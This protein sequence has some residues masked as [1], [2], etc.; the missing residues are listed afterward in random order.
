MA[1]HNPTLEYLTTT[2]IGEKGQLTVPKQ[3]REDLGLGIGAP[4]A[5]LRLGDGLILLPEQ[6]RFEQ[7]CERV[8]TS[9]TAAGLT[10][11][12]ILA[13]L[14]GARNRVFGRRYGKK[15]ADTGTG[16]VA[17]RRRRSQLGK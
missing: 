5:V 14:P 12:D 17:R 10:A 15:P 2:K 3:F 9:L 11:Q 8:R 7:L 6:R 16:N 1:S 13:T 4:F